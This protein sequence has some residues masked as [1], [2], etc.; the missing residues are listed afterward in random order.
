MA[1]TRIHRQGPFYVH[2]PQELVTEE[3]ELRPYSPE[4]D[5]VIKNKPILKPEWGTKG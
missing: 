3:R 2:N 1:H 4:P 5:Q